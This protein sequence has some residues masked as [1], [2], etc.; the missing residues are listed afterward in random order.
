MKKRLRRSIVMSANYVKE[1]NADMGELSLNIDGGKHWK[2]FSAR[3]I[4]KIRKT[5]VQKKTLFITKPVDRIEIL[6]SGEEKPFIIEKGKIKDDFQ[7]ITD[8]IKR[9]AEKNKV[10]YE[11][12]SSA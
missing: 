11:E 4:E 3:E 10:V 1:F 9:F 7:W 2:R 6:V 8:V 12:S 5:T